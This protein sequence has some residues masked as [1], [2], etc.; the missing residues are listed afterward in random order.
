MLRSA[1]IGFCRNNE[2]QELGV[3]I[4][5]Y[6]KKRIS[7]DELLSVCKNI[8][9]SN[10]KVQKKHNIDIIPSNDFSMYDNVLD[11]T[12]L[13]G[14]IQRRFYW[15]GGRVPLHIY[16]TMAHGQQ[17]DKFDI[18]PLEM[19][20]WLNTNYLYFVPEFVDPIDFEYSSNKPIV[21]YIEAK[22]LNKK[23]IYNHLI[24]WMKFCL[25]I[26]NYS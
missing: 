12:C 25:S 18:F 23:Q 2:K 19:Q 26:M 1:C 7:E 9:I 16:F 20:N 17:K 24:Y 21:E 14:N 4:N 3:A 6:L 8:R 22:A 11:M 13:V 10:W 15:E 5:N